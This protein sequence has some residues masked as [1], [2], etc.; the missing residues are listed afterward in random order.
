MSKQKAMTTKTKFRHRSNL[1]ESVVRDISLRVYEMLVLFAVIVCV[2]AFFLP[3]ENASIWDTLKFTPEEIL[4]KR[5]GLMFFGVFAVIILV[6]RIIIF[7]RRQ[8]IR[9]MEA[10]KKNQDTNE[11]LTTM[12]HGIRTPINGIMGLNTIIG[13]KN[14]EA[15]IEEYVNQIQR[16][17]DSLISNL[18]EILDFS[19]IEQN[20]IEIEE[21]EYN[22]ATM[23]GDC[24][25]LMKERANQKHL[26]FDVVCDPDIPRRLYGDSMRIRQ[27]ILNILSN[28]VKYT[29][30]GSV[31][32]EVFSD[33]LGADQAHLIVKVTDTGI[34]ISEE[35]LPH[36]FDAYSRIDV[37]RIRNVEGTG[38]GMAITKQLVERMGGLIMVT[39]K[40]DEGTMFRVRI[41]QRIVDDT[42]VGDLDLTQSSTSFQKNQWFFA[43]GIR[44]LAVDDVEMNL[45]VLAGMIEPSGIWV[46]VAHS[47]EECLAMAKEER[48]DVILMDDRMPQMD[49]VTCFQRLHNRSNGKNAK[50]P[51][52]MVTANAVR[53]AEEE[54]RKIGFAAYLPKPIREE[55]L[56]AALRELLK[57]KYLEN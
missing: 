42:P 57:G 12:S 2:S 39:S 8:Q 15:A 19:K 1:P 33:Y 9:Y 27:I 31:R 21:A 22:V 28:A 6:Q 41:P 24:Y 11:F 51:V 54:Y 44:V 7:S 50:T 55:E 16:A 47:G 46:D 18:D 36:V 13:R 30:Q 37:Y 4:N 25:Q 20:S 23:I 32:L 49:G 26:Q 48:Y 5:T 10:R 56:I 14:K 43:P 35:A 34:G 38:L 52:M 3:H 53:G 17:G 29:T 40:V 45:K